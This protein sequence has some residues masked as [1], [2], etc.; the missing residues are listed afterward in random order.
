MKVQILGGHGGVTVGAAATSFLIDDH[1]LIDAGSVATAIPIEQQ[2]KIDNILISHSHLDHVKDL[3]FLCDN[4]FGLRPAPFQVWSHQT[5]VDT[6]KRHIFN[7]TLWPDF[8]VLPSANKPT[9]HFNA[10]TPE[11]T[12]TIGRYQV[13]PVKVNHPNDAMGYIV[14]K[15]N[16]AVL[17]T[18]DTATT[19]RIWEVAKGF[20]NIKA[21]SYAACG[22]FE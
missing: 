12:V 22:H 20:N 16:T 21:Q 11:Q 9:I 7:D 8:T 13:T 1:L 10:L 15:D 6:I 14:E 2:V 19:E 18:L 4:C 5:V 3:A 17:F